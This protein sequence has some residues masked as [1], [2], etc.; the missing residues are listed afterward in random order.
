ME[1]AEKHHVSLPPRPHSTSLSLHSCAPPLYPELAALSVLPLSSHPKYLFLTNLLSQHF[2]AQSP[3]KPPSNSSE[4]SPKWKEVLYSSLLKLLTELTFLDDK[5]EI[6]AGLER[7]YQWFTTKTHLSIDIPPIRP[8]STLVEDHE[9]GLNPSPNRPF[10]PGIDAFPTLEAR[11]KSPCKSPPALSALVSA[12]LHRTS[13]HTKLKNQDK[14]QG[15][16]LKTRKSEDVSHRYIRKWSI[17]KA[18]REERAGIRSELR[19]NRRKRTDELSVDCTRRESEQD[20]TVPCV[21]LRPERGFEE[22]KKPLFGSKI[23]RL[24]RKYRLFAP[25]SPL[26]PSISPTF[27]LS[28]PSPSRDSV[29][30]IRRK[31]ASRQVA[32]SYRALSLGLS[33]P[34]GLESVNPAFLPKGGEYLMINPFSELGK[35]KT[36]KRKG[37]K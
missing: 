13:P 8:L 27:T 36:T 20:R 22:E 7:I 25:D 11:I 9:K 16:P 28:P 4:K 12:Y 17:H 37:G 34:E 19:S 3:G 32:S 35:T 31:M 33:P 1:T 23:Q 14:W 2:S 26:S 5:Q 15:K 18:K 10:L 6:K 30:S 24:R 29:I 21:D